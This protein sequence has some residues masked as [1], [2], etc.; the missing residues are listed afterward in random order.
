MLYTLLPPSSAGISTFGLW[1]KDRRPEAELMLKSPMSVPPSDQVMVSVSSSRPVKVSTSRFAVVASYSISAKVCVALLEVI[2]GVSLTWV[3]VTVTS[4]VPT[5][6]N[7]SVA[8]TT[9]T[10]IL[11]EA[12]LLIASAT[13]TG[14]SKSGRVSKDRTPV[15]GSISN[16]GLSVPLTDQVMTGKRILVKCRVGAY[17]VVRG[18]EVLIQDIEFNLCEAWPGSPADDR[19]FVH[20]V[21]VESPPSGCPRADRCD[22][23][24]T[25]TV[26]S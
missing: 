5:L 11:L 14:F 2:S 7:S 4:K 12:P 17:L 22:C 3:T 20:I 21:D 8:S 1:E 6:S 16:C 23:L 9:M 10:Y 15:I 19:P 25:F 26:T 18:G 13:S 24:R